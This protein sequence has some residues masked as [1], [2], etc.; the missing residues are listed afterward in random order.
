MLIIEIILI[1]LTLIA[2][3]SIVLTTM[4][5]GISPSPSSGKTL[6]AIAGAAENSGTGPIVDLGSGWGTLVAA[7]AKKYPHRQVIGYE[8][9]F[10]PWLFSS[11]RKYVSGLDNLTLF[12]RNFL[13]ANLS[14]ASVLTCY[15]FPGG[16]VSL[17][18]KLE[19]DNIKDVLIVS[20]TF[21]LPD[22]EPIK[23]IQVKDI[24]STP[25]YLYRR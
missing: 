18:D 7:L 16:M 1:A 14:N 12:R 6:R 20:S 23:V 3:I 8:L 10:V 13:N 9:S 15:L 24:Y 17:K 5:T 2:A 21:A 22:S 25:V 11:I 19:R 4:K